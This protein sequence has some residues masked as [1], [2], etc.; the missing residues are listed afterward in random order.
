MAESNRVKLRRLFSALSVVYFTVSTASAVRV[1]E[2][3]GDT[4]DAFCATPKHPHIVAR[5]TAKTTIKPGSIATL[6]VDMDQAHFFEPGEFG[7]RL[8]A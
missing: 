1:T 4:V 2:P 7:R 5:V 8:T 3:L 6:A